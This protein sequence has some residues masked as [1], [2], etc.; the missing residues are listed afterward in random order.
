MGTKG[1]HTVTEASVIGEHDYE[2]KVSNGYVDT[3]FVGA[4]T[5][6]YVGG[7]AVSC[8]GVWVDSAVGAH[9]DLAAALKVDFVLGSK[10]DRVFCHS[11]EVVMGSKYVFSPAETI[12]VHGGHQ[13]MSATSSLVYAPEVTVAG[14]TSVVITS[15]LL[16]SVFVGTPDTGPYGSIRATPDE[17][18][19]SSVVG[20]AAGTVAVTPQSV[21]LQSSAGMTS[22][23]NA[24]PATLEMSSG[25]SKLTLTPNG[26]DGNCPQ[27]FFNGMGIQLGQPP[28]FAP[29]PPP[30][31]LPA[32]PPVLEIEAAAAAEL[33]AEDFG[34]TG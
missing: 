13:I 22:G 29:V 24:Q 7:L 18:A 11:S 3:V 21:S 17:V 8:L 28:V 10:Y 1:V 27:W 31:G 19:L 25:Q 20:P 6:T 4:T 15:D 32:A 2:N 5:G 34:I 16:A 23:I 33:E 9:I 12:E 26:F 30:A 14:G